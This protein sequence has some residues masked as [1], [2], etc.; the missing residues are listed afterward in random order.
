GPTIDIDYRDW[1]NA[2]V[3]LHKPPMAMWQVALSYAILGVNTFA[4]RFPSLI[5]SSLAVWLTYLIGKE[6]IDTT[7]GL[8]G[9]ALQAFN[10]PIAMLVHGHVFSDHV[11]I[12]LLFWTEL[13]IWLLLRAVR[14]PPQPS[15]GVPGE[16]FRWWILCGVAQGLAFLS[17]SYPA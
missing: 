7:P 14:P 11:D 5:L 9:A 2:R 4:L 17:K 3:F 8:V 6:L 13:A 16:G 10:A 15:P 12:S 1:Q